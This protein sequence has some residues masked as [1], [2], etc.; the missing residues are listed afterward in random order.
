[1]SQSERIKFSGMEKRAKGKFVRKT[2]SVRAQRLNK[3]GL[4][5]QGTGERRI[6]EV[7]NP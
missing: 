1:M 7:D 6:D 2:P 5:E 4:L 3:H